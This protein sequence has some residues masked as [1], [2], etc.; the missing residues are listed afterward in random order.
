MSGMITE[1]RAWQRRRKWLSHQFLGNSI[2]NLLL[3]VVRGSGTRTVLDFVEWTE[4][5]NA[6]AS[7]LQSCLALVVQASYALSPARFFEV[8][9]WPAISSAERHEVGMVLENDWR[10]SFGMI[11]R[12]DAAE[13]CAKA[14]L[15]A[16]GEARHSLLS[17]GINSQR[18]RHALTRLLE[19]VGDL[20]RALKDL[21]L[22]VVWSA[23]TAPR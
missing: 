22:S 2:S 13:V 10:Q 20:R 17:A 19:K 21:D 5:L 11:E 14:A 23:A 18:F 8:D 15:C 9:G 6:W 1:H 12:I 3:D 7:G 4:T 16:C